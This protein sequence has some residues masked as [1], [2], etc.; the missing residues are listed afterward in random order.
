M[1]FFTIDSITFFPF[2]V[3][4]KIV[5]QYIEMQLNFHGIDR[6]IYENA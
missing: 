5:K 2:Q 1:E 6:L 4:C 3:E